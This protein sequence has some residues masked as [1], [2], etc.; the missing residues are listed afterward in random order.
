MGP[1]ECHA[2]A[3]FVKRFTRRDCFRR[4]FGRHG[5]MFVAPDVVFVQSRWRSPRRRP[6][7]VRYRERTGQARFGDGVEG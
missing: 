6:S 1:R 5:C 2:R 4:A 7:L 3:G